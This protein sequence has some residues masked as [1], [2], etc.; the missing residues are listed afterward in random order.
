MNRFYTIFVFFLATIS[1][2]AQKNFP[3]EFTNLNYAKKHLSEHILDLDL[4][5]GIYDFENVV[6]AGAGSQGQTIKQHATL[7]ILDVKKI[8]NT[9][10]ELVDADFLAVYAN[11]TNVNVGGALGVIKTLSDGGYYLLK[12]INASGEVVNYRFKLDNATS[13]NISDKA[14]YG[15]YGAQNEAYRRERGRKTAKTFYLQG[16]ARVEAM[17]APQNEMFT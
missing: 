11:G 4:I 7:V 9:G 6:E 10:M 16:V 13:F 15:N 1:V 14:Y 5:E 12:S 2:I 17:M 3:K 8:K